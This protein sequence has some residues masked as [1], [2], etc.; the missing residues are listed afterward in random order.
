MIWKKGN[1]EEGFKEFQCYKGDG[2]VK[3]LTKGCVQSRSHFELNGFE[4]AT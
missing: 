3:N 2:R 4:D 1:N